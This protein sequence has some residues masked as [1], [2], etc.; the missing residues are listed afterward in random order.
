MNDLP[1]SVAVDDANTVADEMD[2]LEKVEKSSGDAG[3]NLVDVACETLITSAAVKREGTAKE[4]VSV[5]AVCCKPVE[6]L[7]FDDFN[8]PADMEVRM[9]FFIRKLKTK[10]VS[11]NRKYQKL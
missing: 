11:L 2:Q 9:E 4:T 5:D 1:V 10:L 6:P 3:K 7:N 8:S